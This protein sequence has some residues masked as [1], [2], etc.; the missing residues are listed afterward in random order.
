MIFSVL[1]QLDCGAGTFQGFLGGFGV[2]GLCLLKHGLGN[3]V[4]YG[5]GLT[6]TQ[7]GDVLDSL[8]D[9]YLLGAG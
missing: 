8:D 9:G 6:Q 3:A 4:D 7:T 1:S 2:F 5:L